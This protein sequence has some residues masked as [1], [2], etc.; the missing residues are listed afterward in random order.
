MSGSQWFALT[1]DYGSVYGD[2]T[3]KYKFKK[4]PHL[5]DI[6]DGKVREMIEQTIEPHDNNIIKY[7]DPDQQY[8]GG[9]GN[10]DYHNLVKK[11]FGEEYDGTIIEADKLKD[12]KKYSKEDMEGA[13]EVV[14]WKDFTELL[15]EETE[16]VTGGKP[17]KKR[18]TIKKRKNI[19][20]KRIK[21][22]RF[23]RQQ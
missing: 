11:Y 16:S 7:S 15:K 23:K 3:I 10:R 19:N 4:T 9:Q 1:N 12:G 22:R 5:L 18:R 6:G 8:S 2:I 14:I 17:I 20:R 13:T 21:S